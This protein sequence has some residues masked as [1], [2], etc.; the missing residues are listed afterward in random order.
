MTISCEGCGGACCKVINVDLSGLSPDKR[1]L[2]SM[3]GVVVGDKVYV[4]ATC[5][6]LVD[7]RC[8]AYDLRPLI[9]QQYAVGG[10][11]CLG[12]REAAGI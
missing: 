12:V 1:R 5:S 9:C 4:P 10:P 11:E 6:C 2:L 7:G 8:S 3:R